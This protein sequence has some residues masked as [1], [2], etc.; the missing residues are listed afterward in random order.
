MFYYAIRHKT[1]ENMSLHGLEFD[2]EKRYLIYMQQNL[3]A[4]I[5]FSASGLGVFLI[6]LSLYFILICNGHRE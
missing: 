4:I 5:R 2:F 3:C 1:A 6:Q